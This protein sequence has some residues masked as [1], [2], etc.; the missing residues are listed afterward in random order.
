VPLGTPRALRS[1]R[2]FFLRYVG[3]CFLT[4]LTGHMVYTL[5]RAHSLHFVSER[6]FNWLDPSIVLVEVGR[7]KTCGVS[8]RRACRVIGQ[9]RSSQRYKQVPD[10]FKVGLRDRV[11]A[12]ATEFGRYGYK[13]ITC[14]QQ[15]PSFLRTL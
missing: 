7:T 2:Q 14:T 12:M 9:I 15:A 5:Y 6:V 4:V 8:E 13:Q 1:L 10:E 11:I 3:S